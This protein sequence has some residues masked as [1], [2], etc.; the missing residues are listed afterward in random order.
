VLLRI[1]RSNEEKI[2]LYLSG[3]YL[4]VSV[5]RGSQRIFR[6]ISGTGGVAV[7]RIRMSAPIGVGSGGEMLCL[8]D[9]AE[10]R[11]IERLTG[12]VAP[13]GVIVSAQA[14]SREVIDLLTCRGIPYIIVK[15]AFSN[16]FA[17]RVAL[18]DGEYDRVIIDPDVET[19]NF[20]WK[21]Y[22]KKELFLPRARSEKGFDIRRRSGGGGLMADILGVRGEE[23]FDRLRDMAESRCTDSLTLRL[24]VPKANESEET[25]LEDCEAIFRAAIYGN[26]S[27]QIEGYSSRTDMD[28]ALGMLMKAFCRLESEG[29][30]FNGYLP[31]GVLVDA[32][33]WL[34]QGSVF[35][36]A[37]F[38]CFDFDA[39][40]ARMM[41]IEQRELADAELP[42]EAIMRLWEQYFCSFAPRMPMRATSGVLAQHPIFEEW[43]ERAG[44]DEIYLP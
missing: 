3:G 11:A 19:L 21:I 32:P 31:R 28:N 7:G 26:F 42:G 10:D 30:E 29:R 5:L 16:E 44:I 25:F 41:G 23:L 20:F 33:V 12:M 40:T 4:Q 18:L 43:A 36:S 35:P 27:L 9:G 8:F 34:M 17:G 39:I 37:D 22:E 15:E 1:K 38:I 24:R 2:I 13:A 6:G 14:I